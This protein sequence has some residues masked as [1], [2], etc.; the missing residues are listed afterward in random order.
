MKV[1]VCQKIF[2][3]Q[4]SPAYCVHFSCRTCRERFSMPEEWPL[5]SPSKNQLSHRLV[6][7]TNAKMP[8]ITCWKIH[9]RLVTALCLSTVL[10]MK[11]FRTFPRSLWI[12]QQLLQISTHWK[13]GKKELNYIIRRSCCNYNG[14]IVQNDCNVTHLQRQ[15][16]DFVYVHCYQWNLSYINYALNHVGWKS[17]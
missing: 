12:Q 9:H 17:I 3:L 6:V 15:T 5:Q 16:T 2:A 1:V 10:F 11:P 8:T 4:V 7:Q 14:Y 13:R